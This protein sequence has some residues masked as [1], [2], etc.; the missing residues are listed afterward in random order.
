VIEGA[1]ATARRGPRTNSACSAGGSTSP[2]CSSPEAFEPIA[3]GEVE[4]DLLEDSDFELT[5]RFDPERNAEESSHLA[6]FVR[7]ISG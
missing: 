1:T 4:F 3:L 2:G 5:E 7:R 6:R